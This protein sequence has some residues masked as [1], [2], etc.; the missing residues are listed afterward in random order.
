MPKKQTHFLPT[1]DLIFCSFWAILQCQILQKFEKSNNTFLNHI[2]MPKFENKT[3]TIDLIFRLFWAILQCQ[4][5]PKFAKV[6][7][8]TT[9]FYLVLIQFLSHILMPK[10]A[11]VWKKQ[12]HY[13]WSNFSLILSHITIPKF[14]WK[15]NTSLSHISKAK[16]AKVWKTQHY[17]WSNFSLILSHITMP[18]FAKVW[19]KLPL[20]HSSFNNIIALLQK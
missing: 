17:Y 13:Y 1:I 18:K 19:K 6:W 16:F 10:F 14:D 4:S 20:V 11:K 8:T 12:K 15:K 3:T 9:N 2:S 5:L 7:K